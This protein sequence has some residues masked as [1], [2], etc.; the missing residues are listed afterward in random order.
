MITIADWKAE[1]RTILIDL[2]AE[3]E[4]RFCYPAGD[5]R[6]TDAE[7]SEQKRTGDLVLPAVLAEFYAE[8]GEL[9]TATSGI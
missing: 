6:V 1:I 3:F 7:I 2:N 5:N 9:S 4:K 8:V